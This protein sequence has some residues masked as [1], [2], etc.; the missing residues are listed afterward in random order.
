[1]KSED[2]ITIRAQCSLT[3]PREYL[4]E[5]ERVKLAREESLL[6]AKEDSV[7]RMM[8][9]LAVDRARHPQAA[10]A[11]QWDQSVDQDEGEDDDL[12]VNIIDRSM[13]SLPIIRQ[14]TDICQVRTAGRVSTSI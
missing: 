2:I 6:A 11:D 10:V 14:L 4:P 5:I 3:S 9:D 13:F 1:M 8:K 7:N 12:D